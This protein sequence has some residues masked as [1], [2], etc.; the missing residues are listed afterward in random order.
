MSSMYLYICMW[1]GE[2]GVRRPGSVRGPNAFFTKLL[3]TYIF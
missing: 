2:S 1:V 3:E